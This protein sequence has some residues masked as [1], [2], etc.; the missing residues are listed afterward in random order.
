MR[1]LVD[2]ARRTADGEASR[3]RAAQEA[4]Y[5]F[6]TAMAGNMPRYE[7]ACRALFA[8]DQ[9]RLSDCMAAWPGAVQGYVGQLLRQG[10]A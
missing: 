1:R 9:P 4:A 5:R 8:G 2:Q 6:M 7:D 10:Q 3:R